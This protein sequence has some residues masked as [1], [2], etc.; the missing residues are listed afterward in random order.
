MAVE[1]VE[2]DMLK[3]YKI[4]CKDSGL[5]Y[6]LVLSDKKTLLYGTLLI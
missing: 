4:I 6:L 1:L 5:Q 3:Y 2:V